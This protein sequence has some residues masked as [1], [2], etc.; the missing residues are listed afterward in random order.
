MQYHTLQ[1]SKM[2]V[3]DLKNLVKTGEGTFL[4]FK[5][6]ISNPG[7]I[8]REVSAFANTGGGILLIGVDDDK[9]LVGLSSYQEQLYL[10]DQT[11]ALCEPEIQHTVEVL[12]YNY[13][14]FLIIKIEE[15]DQKPVRVNDGGHA[16]VYIR[17]R[18]QS[19]HASREAV[20][21]MQHESSGQGAT[22]EFGPCEQKLLRYLD[23]YQRITVTDF[24]RLVN[25]GRNR[26][27]RILVNL[28]NAG[29]LI[30]SQNGSQDYFTLSYDVA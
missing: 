14:D 29:I 26:A 21:I 17:V 28:V 15:A 2:S 27:S 9:S 10:L 1:Q 22:F 7:K 23:E 13:R 8:A 12:L 20:M 18:D 6:T 4:E 16:D 25:V 19:V 24:S 3:K 30:L 11:F 5:R